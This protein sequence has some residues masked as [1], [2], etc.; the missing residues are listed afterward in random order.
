MSPRGG[1]IRRFADLGIVTRKC[2]RCGGEVGT[3]QK[4]GHRPT[5]W[6]CSVVREEYVDS[7]GYWIVLASGWRT[8]GGEHAIVENTKREANVRLADIEPCGCADCRG[9]K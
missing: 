3:T 2:R 1:A 7:D 9:T 8:P 6:L 5:C 4:R